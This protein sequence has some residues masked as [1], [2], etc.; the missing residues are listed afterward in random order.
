MA[1]IADIE[2]E[3]FM[4]SAV[5]EDRNSLRFLWVKGI[6]KDQPETIIYSSI[7]WYLGL[8]QVHFY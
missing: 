6:T 3:F 1:I 5:E 8:L 4:V 7:T 2:K